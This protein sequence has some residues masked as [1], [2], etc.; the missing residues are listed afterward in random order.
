MGSTIK[1]Q[2]DER[3]VPN[4]DIFYMKE[5]ERKLVKENEL[6]RKK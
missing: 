3:I 2:V 4:K 1:A 6:K 5:L